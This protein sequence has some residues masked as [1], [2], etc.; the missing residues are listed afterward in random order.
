[1]NENS[2]LSNQEYLKYKIHTLRGV[3]VMLD[4]D[5]A[6]LYNIETRALKQAV[7]RNEKRF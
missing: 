3:S 5:L 4:R 1:M 2:I 7:N 6:V